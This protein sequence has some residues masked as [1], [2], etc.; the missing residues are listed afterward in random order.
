MSIISRLPIYFKFLFGDLFSPGWIH[1][2]HMQ[3]INDKHSAAALKDF[4]NVLKILGP[5]GKIANAI[6]SSGLDLNAVIEV[7]FSNI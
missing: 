2:V 7:I 6:F 1:N 3:V 4:D 5:Q